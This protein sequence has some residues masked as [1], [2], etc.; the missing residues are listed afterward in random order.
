MKSKT[1][2]EENELDKYI[3]TNYGSYLNKFERL[4]YKVASSYEKPDG[5]TNPDKMAKA[6]REKY[7]NLSTPRIDAAL[8]KGTKL[9]KREVRKRIQFQYKEDISIKR[10]GKCDKIVA[11]PKA[12]QCLWCGNDW[13]EA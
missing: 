3:L 13:H 11:T 6:L 5:K 8:T 4:G 2:I 10:C 7:G 9:F 1:Y 12:K